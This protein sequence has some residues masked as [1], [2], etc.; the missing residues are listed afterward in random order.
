M[1]RWRDVGI[2]GDLR[3]IE[4]DTCHF[5]YE[6]PHSIGDKIGFLGAKIPLS[7]LD[8]LSNVIPMRR[9][10]CQGALN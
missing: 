2:E 9:E 8:Q 4:T 7:S 5:S 6:A 10:P 1:L 3:I